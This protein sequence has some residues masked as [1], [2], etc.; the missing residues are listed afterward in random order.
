MIDSESG[1][2]KLSTSN[3]PNFLMGSS[4]RSQATASDKTE[5]AEVS[6]R[7]SFPRRNNPHWREMPRKPQPHQY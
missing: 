1:S 6:E 7:R 3:R 5:E 2:F 4:S